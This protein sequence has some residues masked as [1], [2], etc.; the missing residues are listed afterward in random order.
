MNWRRFINRSHED[1][2]LRQELESFI[3]ITAE[4]VRRSGHGTG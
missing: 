2:E 3:E 1:D 4:R